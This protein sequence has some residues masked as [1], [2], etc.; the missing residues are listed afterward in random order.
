MDLAICRHLKLGEGR[1]G[2]PAMR[3][4][5]YCHFHAGAHRGVPA[6]DLW[7]SPKARA[8][9]Q[10]HGKLSEAAQQ[11]VPSLDYELLGEATAIQRGFMRLVQGIT[12]GLLSTRQARLM[13]VALQTAAA[14][15]G[16]N[17]ATGDSAV[18][19]NEL[20]LPIPSG[21]CTSTSESREG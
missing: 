7:P 17:T 2:S 14:N 16:D 21:C 4:Q 13:L 18:T 8:L 6:V 12:Q 11:N 3:G 10:A 9:R 20:R 19:S 5:D 15:R 1:C